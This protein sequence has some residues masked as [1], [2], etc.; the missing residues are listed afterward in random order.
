MNVKRVVFK[1]V[2]FP[3]AFNLYHR[4]FNYYTTDNN[5]NRKPNTNKV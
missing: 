4:T 3:E 1:P 5:G 2:C